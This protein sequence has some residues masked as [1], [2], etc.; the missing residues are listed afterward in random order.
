MTTATNDGVTGDYE[1]CEH[2]I[3]EVSRNLGRDTF[4][5]W[6]CVPAF[7]LVGV[8]Q[9]LTG[10]TSAGMRRWL[11]LV[12]PIMP[13]AELRPVAM[14]K[15]DILRYTVIPTAETIPALDTTPLHSGDY[16]L[17]PVDYRRDSFGS[18]QR[19]V[20]QPRN[21]FAEYVRIHDIHN[22]LTK[23]ELYTFPPSVEQSVRLRDSLDTWPNEETCDYTPFLN[24]SNAC[25]MRRDLLS[26]FHANAFSIDVDDNF[27]IVVFRDM[28]SV[29]VP[30]HI[31]KSHDPA[32][33]GPDDRFLR[34]HFRWSLLVNLFGGDI[35]EEY[36]TDR[37]VA[38][39]DQLGMLRGSDNPLAPIDDPRWDSDVIGQ[40]LWESLMRSTL[41]SAAD[42]PESSEDNS[43]LY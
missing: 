11:H 39:M 22:T 29:T 27:R 10:M 5:F 9:K 4:V 43:A 24:A 32:C 12:N 20:I 17:F 25:I 8:N 3:S 23:R 7:L 16:G 31:P 15:F 42:T 6:P 1:Y 41:Y 38:V 21:S 35:S 40:A 37:V 2:L 28:G 19:L 13:D 33:A 30:S 36:D 18:T 34:E 26:L 14:R